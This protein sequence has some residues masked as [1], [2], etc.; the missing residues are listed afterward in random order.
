M[1]FSILHNEAISEITL[2]LLED[3]GWYNV[4]YFTGGL[5]RFGKGQGCQFFN[6]N[7]INKEGKTPFK[8]DFCEEMNEQKCTGDYL[9]RGVCLFYSV[10]KIPIE[11]QYYD[12]PKLVG[13][14]AMNGYPVVA[15]TFS[16]NYW[17]SFHCRYGGNAPN[18]D[19]LYGEKLSPTSLCFISFFFNSTMT[20][21]NNI[22]EICYPVKCDTDK[23]TY[24]VSIGSKT[25]TCAKGDTIK[26][27][28]GYTG[29][30]TCNPYERICTGTKD[31]NNLYE[32]AMNESLPIDYLQNSQRLTI[33][34]I[35]LVFVAILLL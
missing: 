1:T 24:D 26:E 30:F 7:C 19:L 12:N 20:G 21:V 22:G 31:C 23:K 29:N 13:Y 3:S 5:F 28:E 4:N 34:Y 8:P 9:L 6:E 14:P 25:V 27:V 18:S 17:R 2:A 33:Q 11:Y 15:N 16:S 10:D 35:M 32:C